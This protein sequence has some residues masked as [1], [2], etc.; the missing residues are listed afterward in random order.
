MNILA[1]MLLMLCRPVTQ[2]D[3]PLEIFPRTSWPM[4][5]QMKRSDFVLSAMFTP[6]NANFTPVQVQKFFFLI[7]MN[8]AELIGGQKF[9]FTPYNYGPFNREVYDELE[10]LR[11][12]DLI[13]CHNKGNLRYYQLTESGKKRAELMLPEVSPEALDYIKKASDF[14]RS[15]DFSQLV[16][17]IYKAYPD[18][19]A[20]SVFQG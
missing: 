17:A 18:M 12:T 15:L 3:P 13:E 14:V 16:S 20:N 9:H 6:D 7:D 2:S 8:V 11:F 1:K 10:F 4:E 5:E 19:R